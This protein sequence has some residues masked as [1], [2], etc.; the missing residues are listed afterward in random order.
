MGMPLEELKEK[1]LVIKESLGWSRVGK[2]KNGD[3]YLSEVSADAVAHWCYVG[4]APTRTWTNVLTPW[5]ELTE[6]ELTMLE[7]FVV[8]KYPKE[9]TVTRDSYLIG[10]KNEESGETMAVNLKDKKFTKTYADA[11]KKPRDIKRPHPFFKGMNGRIVAEKIPADD[12]F[13]KLVD[14]II[15]KESAC[16]N[17]GTFL[18]RLFDNIHLETYIS[19][20]VPFDYN[21][22]VGYDFF[23]KDVRNILN[24]HE[25]TYDRTVE[26]FF[27]NNHDVGK[28]MLAHIK[29]E[30]DFVSVFNSIA[31]NMRDVNIL[32]ENYSYDVKALF[33]YAKERNWSS[34][35]N[36]GYYRSQNRDLITYMCDYARM[37][38]LV[39]PNGFDKYPKD[40]IDYHDGVAKLYAKEQVKFDEINFQKLIDTKWEYEQKAKKPKKGEEEDAE[41]GYCVIYP[42]S[43]TAIQEEGRLLGH[44]VGSY[45]QYVLNGTSTIL[46]MRDKTDLETPLVTIE[47]KNGRITQS[48]GKFNRGLT[49]EEKLFLTEYAEKKRLLYNNTY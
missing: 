29:D 34:G 33:T 25:M 41:T 3:L 40:I 12:N 39:F 9:Y 32:I 20:K 4:E 27:A 1:M 37:A 10:F 23:D 2:Y 42:K 26:Q 35:R 16:S 24:K 8:L 13:K 31:S 19:A 15:K 44:C 38:D 49:Y 6:D 21:I 30:E 28:S 45:V 22:R 7:K 48:R 46:F 18:I 5:E 36:N 17:F 11:K 47:V 14:T 43:A